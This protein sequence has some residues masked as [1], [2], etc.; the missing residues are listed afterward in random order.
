LWAGWATKA[1][2]ARVVRE[3]LPRFEKHGG[4]VTSLRAKAGRQWAWPNGW[5]PLQWIVVA[6]LQRYGYRADARRIMEKWCAHCAAVFAQTGTMWEKY[7]VVK[8]G[9][10]LEAGLYGSVKGFGW[11]N[12]VFV[13]F[14]RRLDIGDK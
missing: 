10:R 7:N 4:L 3:W 13:D 1:Q 11:S 9:A 2:A 6:G 8:T 12:A 14:A 5:A